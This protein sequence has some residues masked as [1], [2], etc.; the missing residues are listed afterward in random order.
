[1]HAETTRRL[2]AEQP[3]PGFLLHDHARFGPALRACMARARGGF[4]PADQAG[5]VAS[6]LE[7]IA[8]INLARLGD[9]ARRHWYPC[10]ADDLLAAAPKLG[11]ER[12]AIEQLLVRCGFKA[13]PAGCTGRST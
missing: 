4:S 12:D 2:G 11:V 13:N 1:M 9:P 7:A 3:T 5:M 6:V 8:P 10:L